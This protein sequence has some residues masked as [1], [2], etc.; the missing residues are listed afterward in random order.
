MLVAN[1]PDINGVKKSKSWPQKISVDSKHWINYE[2][3]LFKILPKDFDSYQHVTN[4]DVFFEKV[5]RV[6]KS[7]AVST[8]KMKK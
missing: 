8:R 1:K 3:I 4:E 2:K 7:R 6:K 5:S